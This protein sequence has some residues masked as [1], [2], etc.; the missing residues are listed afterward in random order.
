M[1]LD[2]YRK[3]RDFEE[4]AEPDGSYSDSGRGPLRFVVQ[5]HAATR[6]HYD[7]RLELD[8]VLKSWAVPKGPSLNPQDKRLAKMTEDHPFD[9]RHFEGV[10]PKGSYGAGTMIIWDEGNYHAPKAETREESEKSLREGLNNGNLKFFLDGEKLKG[11][12]ALVRMKDGKGDNWLLIKK[13]DEFASHDDILEQDHS[14]RSGSSLDEVREED[15]ARRKG[16]QGWDEDELKGLKKLGLKKSKMPSE[17]RPMLASL[18]EQA[19]DR[20]DWYFEIKW[21]GYRAISET[22]QETVRLYSRNLLSFEEKFHPIIKELEKINFE[23]VLDGEVVVVDEEGRAHFKLLQRYNKTGE[24]LL[25]YYIFDL[26]YLDGYDLQALPLEKRKEI[27][28]RALPVLPRLK[29][30]DHIK[31]MGND[32][33]QAAQ[34]KGIEGII[35]KDKNSRYRQGVRSSEWLKVKALLQQKAVIGGFTEPKGSRKDFGALLLGVYEGND[36]IYIG[37]TGGGFD[38]KELKEVKVKLEPLARKK[39]PF[40]QKPK[41]NAPATWVEPNLVCEVRFSEWSHDLIMRQPIYLGLREDIDPKEIRREVP[42]PTGEVQRKKYIMPDEE[43]TTVEIDGIEISLSNQ[44]KMYWPEDKI[45][46]GDMVDYYREIAPVLLPYLKDR[47]ESLHRFPEGIHGNSFYQK[48]FPQAPDWVETISIESD[49][50][51]NSTNYILCQNT[52]TLL[53]MANLGSI[54]I[55]PWNSRKQKL[56]FPDYLVID[57]DP[58]DRPFEDVI[59]VAQAVRKVLEELEILSCIKTTG[60]R[61]MH[62]F[63]PTG[64]KYSYEQVR[65]FAQ[66]LCQYI[67]TKEP[68]ITSLERKPKNRQGL[69]YLDYL[70]NK[71]GATLAAAYSLRPRPKAPVSTPLKWEEVKKGISP[72]DYTIR[73]ILKRVDKHGDLWEDVL[74]KGIDM[75]NG[76]SALK[77]VWGS[78]SGKSR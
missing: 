48:D 50:D 76:L 63:I 37:H 14:V 13:K 57:L 52:A 12:F 49:T 32:L 64:G 36:L 42:L 15:E 21:D 70:Q 7:L 47:P 61:G 17:V 30:S 20:Q 41:T 54:E 22:G 38:A 78:K 60:Q 59:K 35:A 67:H 40:K 33:F 73:N 23:A 11:E 46:K 68:Q 44:N 26:L 62:V 66:L 69:I 18:T 31:G 65:Q 4:T 39:S 10:I 1:A 53:Y 71:R 29:Y 25:V 55:H 27:L 34:N 45:T 3:K 74:G 58:S 9:Y 16:W 19:F 77:N 75:E 24:G 43:K 28:K 72:H 6:L 5:K 51:G 8:G 56:D 2:E